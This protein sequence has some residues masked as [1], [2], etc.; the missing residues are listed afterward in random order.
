MVASGVVDAVLEIISRGASAGCR[1]LATERHVS[2]P[3]VGIENEAMNKY[4]LAL[5][6]LRTRE[7]RQ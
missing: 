4:R 3:I 2:A 5:P 1:L 6:Q 7:V